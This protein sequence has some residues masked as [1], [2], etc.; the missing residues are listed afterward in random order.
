MSSYV[1]ISESSATYLENKTRN[2]HLQLGNKNLLKQYFFKLYKHLK[3]GASKKNSKYFV[4]IIFKTHTH[5]CTH[6]EWNG[7]SDFYLFIKIRYS[8]NYFVISFFT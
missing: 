4:R 2:V 6:T 3:V 8:A 5:V 1:E 7:K